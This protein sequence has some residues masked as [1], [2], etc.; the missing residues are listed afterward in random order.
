VKMLR[1]ARANKAQ[2]RLMREARVWKFLDHPNIVPLIGFVVGEEGPGF[3]APWYACGD[4][5]RYLENASNIRREYLCEDV[6]AGLRYLHE[7]VPPII[8]GDLK[9]ANIL[10]GEDGRAALCDFGL[11]MVLDGRTTGFTSSNVGGTLRFMA[12]EQFS[13]DLGGRSVHSDIYSY[14]CTYAEIMTGD[15]PYNWHRTDAMI[16][17]AISQGELP[18]K[19]DS[20]VSH[21]NIGFLELS[22]AAEPAHRPTISSICE[23]LGIMDYVDR[24]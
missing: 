13:D 11:S 9:G 4:I 18:Y 3:V 15:V 5:R 22:W 8:H 6:A 21:H 19:I 1:V 7:R 2:K 12:P 20:I 23:T 14:A 10:V 24:L 16:M 17:R